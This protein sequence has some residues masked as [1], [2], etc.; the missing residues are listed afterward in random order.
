MSEAMLRIE[1]EHEVALVILDNPPVNAV[2]QAMRAG[3][4]AALAALEADASVKAIVLI[5]SGRTF[6]AGADIRE[7]DGEPA[8]PHLPD[9]IAAISAC[10]KPII[11]A[12]HGTALGG[13]YEI[14]LGCDARLI[15]PDGMIGLPEVKLGILPGAG[16]CQ[17][18]PRLAGAATAIDLMTSGRMVKAQEAQQ[19]NLVDRIAQG[20]LRSQAIAMARDWQGRKRRLSEASIAPYG[21]QDRDRIVHAA[22]RKAKGNPAVQAIIDAVFRAETMPFAEAMQAD[23]DAFLTLR[24]GEPARALRH[25]FFAERQAGKRDDL[26]GIEPHPIERVGVIGAGTMGAGIAFAFLQAGYPVLLAEA[27]QEALDAGLARIK[28]MQARGKPADM[29]DQLPDGL[30]TTLALSDLGGCDLVVEAVF[31]DIEVKQALLEKL[32]EL[33]RPGAIIA[34]NTSYLD[35]DQLAGFTGRASDVVGLHF[36][37]PAHVMRLLEIVRGRDTAPNVLASALAVA[38]RLRKLPVIAGVCHG[39]IG[40]RIYA[41]YR[42]QCEMMV[43]EGASPA[44]ID[45]ALEAFGFAMGPFAVTDLSG[46]DIAWRTRQRLASTRDPRERYVAILDRLCE[47]GRFGRKSGAGWYR[48]ASPDAKRE[49]DPQTEAIIA[50]YR[51]DKGIAARDVGEDEIIARAMGAM[52]NEAGL[53]L[54]EGIAERSSDI[55]LVLVNGYGFPA[56]RGGPLFWASRQPQSDIEAAIEQVEK[57]VGFGFRRAQMKAG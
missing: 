16:G 19:L 51:Q 13:G 10:A 18:L 4:L 45:A 32:G 56:T 57:A 33:M 55:D 3:L 20:D 49:S 14:A 43:E 17:R 7:F 28:A 26:N 44:A 31:E 35:L 11:A 15:T 30:S 22:L 21:Q 36:F 46:L 50:Q 27:K 5:G 9:V 47:T 37:S 42:G 1:R 39:F 41:A 54:A 6:I 48:Y 40:N 53:I 34:S 2:A 12:M 52:I 25:L 24:A 38:K 23:R 8:K 29:M